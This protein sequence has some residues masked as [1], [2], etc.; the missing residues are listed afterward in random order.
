[1]ISLNPVNFGTKWNPVV[2]L[3]SPPIQIVMQIGPLFSFISRPQIEHKMYLCKDGACQNFQ[4]LISCTKFR[5][6]QCII[7]SIKMFQFDALGLF[8]GLVISQEGHLK[9][10]YFYT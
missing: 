6:S 1:M 2:S 3:L 9:T 7:V 4:I 5:H 8:R 10:N